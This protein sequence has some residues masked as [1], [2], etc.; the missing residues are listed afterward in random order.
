[1]R[2][3]EAGVFAATPFLTDYLGSGK[4]DA[5]PSQD[6]IDMD[7]AKRVVSG[8]TRII[9][10]FYPDHFETAAVATISCPKA[11]KCPLVTS[12][13]ATTPPFAISGA[14]YAQQPFQFTVNAYGLLRDGERSLL[15]LFENKARPVAV[16]IATRPDAATVTCGGPFAYTLDTPKQGDPPLKASNAT[17]R[18][19]TPY[20][21][22]TAATRSASGAWIAPTLV[23]LRATLG[24][25]V[26]TWQGSGQTTL[27]TGALQ[28]DSRLP[29]GAAAGTRYEDG[30]MVLS[31]RLYVPNVF[32]S[33]LLRLPMPLAAQYWNGTAWATS[34][35][36]SASLVAQ[37]LSPRT[38]RQFFAAD[39][40]TGACK[41]NPLTA[42]VSLP[43]Q[44]QDGKAVLKLQAPA[45]GTVGSVDVGVD[46]GAANAWLP[47]TIGRATFGLYRSPLIYLREVY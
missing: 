43:L 7:P 42:A 13:P 23:Y 47:T 9:G 10:R 5:R 26:Q 37:G 46:N 22:D 14:V 45:R 31:G 41:P 17:Y 1:V 25:S 12:D 29:G 21:A 35:G 2:W 34:D 15:S 16:C 11:L 4:V 44:L 36:D 24:D 32:G 30:L 19:G 27:T 8:T 38:C 28:V 20:A 6:V 33:D 18:L 39:P 40:K 3:Y